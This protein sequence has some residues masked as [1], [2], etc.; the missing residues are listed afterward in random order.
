MNT[1]DNNIQNNVELSEQKITETIAGRKSENGVVE[2]YSGN[3]RFKGSDNANNN[4]EQSSGR[5]KR[6]SSH[7]RRFMAGIVFISIFLTMVVTLLA[8]TSFLRKYDENGTTL[9]NVNINVDTEAQNAVEAV[10]TKCTRSVVGIRTTTSV[11]NFFGGVS[12]ESGEGSGVI[13]RANGYIVTNFHVIENAVENG[14]SKIEVFI[15][16]KETKSYSAKVVGYNIT[17]DL[18]VLKIDADNLPYMEL[19]DSE[20]LRVGQYAVTIGA[21]GGLEFMGSVTYGVISG[22]DRKVSSNAELGLI[23]TDAAINPG[24]SGGALLD[25]KGRL[26]GI[27]S[28]KIVSEEFEGMGFAIPINTA[29]KICDSIISKEDYEEAYLGVSISKTYTASVLKSQGFPV[30]AVVTTVDRNSP[31]EK[32]GIKRGD[33]ITEFAGTK[34]TEYT[35][36]SDALHEAKANS[37][38]NA[39]VYRNGELFTVTIDLESSSQR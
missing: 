19:G 2:F 15:N 38:V 22:L 39:T 10:A 23:Q 30:G 4:L 7:N 9:Q 20:T 37:T 8:T 35:K 1:E 17:T 31:A 11:M 21:P 32:S 13:Y 14:N 34:I 12:S 27:N 26:I 33:I 5:V 36:L 18:A 28:S 29:K 6:K 16:S 25:L 24:N 3:R